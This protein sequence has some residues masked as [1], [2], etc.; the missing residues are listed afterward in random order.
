MSQVT[1]SKS[2]I[3]HTDMGASVITISTVTNYDVE[4]V[5]RERAT[6]QARVIQFM[7][8]AAKSNP[9]DQRGART[10]DSVYTTSGEELPA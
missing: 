4:D 6:S 3:F 10:L 5:V 2:F 8:Q 7:N 1:D 9:N